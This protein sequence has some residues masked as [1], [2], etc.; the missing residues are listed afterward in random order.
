[1]KMHL[2]EACLEGQDYAP[3]V[4][5]YHSEHDVYVDVDLTVKHSQ[6]QA[7]GK[8]KYDYYL[9]VQGPANILKATDC[10]VPYLKAVFEELAVGSAT[11]T[12]AIQKAAQE[13]GEDGKKYV[14]YPVQISVT[15]QTDT[16]GLTLQ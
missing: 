16:S 13:V 8:I 14:H 11:V 1:M 9:A 4:T 10:C 6:Q 15:P 7:D 2:V 3:V 12:F 5:Y